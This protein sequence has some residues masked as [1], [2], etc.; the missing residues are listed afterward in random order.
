ML[1]KVFPSILSQQRLVDGDAANV[2]PVG[3]EWFWLIRKLNYT[4]GGDKHRFLKTRTE[5]PTV[6]PLSLEP[7]EDGTR[8]LIAF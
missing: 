7:R 2:V 1:E 5:S 4:Q 8:S 6:I 3:Y